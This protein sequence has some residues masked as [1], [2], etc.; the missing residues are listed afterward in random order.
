MVLSLTA[1]SFEAYAQSS[2]D[3]LKEI[4]EIKNSVKENTQAVKELNQLIKS[5]KFAVGSGGPVSSVNVSTE[6]VETMSQADKDAFI[7]SLKWQTNDNITAFGSPKAKKGGV[8]R[9]VESSFPPT[10]R[11]TGKNSNSVFNSTLAGLCY[12]TLLDL[13]PISYD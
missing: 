8:L 13:D 2:D 3:L 6:N 10:L 1:F 12:E 9:C 4:R 11:I 7:K 5:G